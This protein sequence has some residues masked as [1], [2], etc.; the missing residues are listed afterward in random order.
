MKKG[1][2]GMAGKWPGA[3]SGQADSS[4][5]Y[6]NFSQ[7]VSISSGGRTIV[8]TFNALGRLV[9]QSGPQGVVSYQYDVAGRR[10]RNPASRITSCGASTASSRSVRLSRGRPD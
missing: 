5:V 8:N 3:P 6:D 4:Y 1:A 9:S 7:P 2:Q 10:T